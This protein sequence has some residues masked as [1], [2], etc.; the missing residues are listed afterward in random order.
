[1]SNKLP[2]DEVIIKST[3]VFKKKNDDTTAICFKNEF[4]GTTIDCMLALASLVVDLENNQ[5]EEYKARFRA[6]FMEYVN[7]IRCRQVIN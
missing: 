1:M 6:D 7:K 5:P 4:D 2:K 3:K